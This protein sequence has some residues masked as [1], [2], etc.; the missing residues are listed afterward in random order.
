[1]ADAAERLLDGFERLN[2]CDLIASAAFEE[3]GAA[4]AP[5]S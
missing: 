2:L 1:V 5:I 3:K 4:P